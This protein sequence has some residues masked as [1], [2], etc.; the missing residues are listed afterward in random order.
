METKQ[1]ITNKN[2]LTDNDITEV[3]KRVKVFIV[4]SSN[5]L[6]LANSNHEYQLPGGHVEENEELLD[7][8][9]REIKEETGIDL[10][11]TNI[12]P[13]VV[14]IGYWKDWPEE[15]KNRK[16]EIYYFEVLTDLKPDMNNIHLTEKEK[17]GNFQLEF[18]PLN[19][20]EE[21]I[22]NNAIIYG[23]KHGI[24]KE[25]LQIIPIYKHDYKGMI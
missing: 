5:E 19:T 11:V 15:G 1:I 12:E 14:S 18:M 9:N 10:N 4:N 17:E 22:N 7:T 16:T 25:M 6:L 13:F 21:V 20:I 23:D 3:V 8:V 24:A 2:N